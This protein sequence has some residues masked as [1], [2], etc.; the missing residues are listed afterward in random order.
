MTTRIDRRMAKLKS[1]GRPALVT[2]IMGGDP[3]YDTSLSIM[4][5]LP[6]SGADVIELGMPFSDPMADG[7]AIQAAGLRA[8]KGGQTLVKT[9]KMA[10]EFRAGDDET[11]I[12]LM[13]YYNPIYIYGVDRFLVDAK[14]SGI[15]GLI[16]VDLPPEMDEELC[17]P[18]LKA[19]INF[20]RLATPT[21]DDKRLPKVLE[22][23]SGFVYYVSMTGITGSALA[24]T[25]KVAAAVKRIKGHTALPV[26][27]GFGVKTAEQARVIGA[28]AD[29]VVVGTAIVNAVANVLGPK[30]EKTADPAE[31][32]ATLVSGLAQGVRT[33][34]LAAAE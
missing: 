10:S 2:Y 33:A 17:I 9:L 31:A 14:A 32:V 16:V 1:E 19:G 26:C 3:D 4:K 20:I 18:A 29:G 21:T 15:D 6:T 34:R 13:G 23:T 7:P 5:A 12:V 22:N 28:S 25:A 24:D 11:P 27:V 30:G 8:L